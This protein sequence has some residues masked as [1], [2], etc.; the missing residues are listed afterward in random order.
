MVGEISYKYYQSTIGLK[1]SSMND[2]FN[3]VLIFKLFRWFQRLGFNFSYDIY[4]ITFN[5]YFMNSK[6][7]IN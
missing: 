2:I 1:F 7:L 6:D 3:I 5:I 4:N